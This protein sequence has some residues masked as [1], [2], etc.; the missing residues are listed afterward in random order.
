MSTTCRHNDLDLVI[1]MCRSFIERVSA[2]RT[3]REERILKENICDLIRRV[4]TKIQT[5]KLLFT[6][7]AFELFTARELTHSVHCQIAPR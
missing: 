3:M 5:T 4:V 7:L 1:V 2:Q 6:R